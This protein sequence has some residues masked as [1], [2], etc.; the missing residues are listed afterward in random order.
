MPYRNP[1]DKAARQ[2]ARRQEQRQTAQAQR[3]GE[4]RQPARA[5][6]PAPLGSTPTP[7]TIVPTPMG[8]MRPTSLSPRRQLLDTYTRL[9]DAGHTDTG[10]QA[11]LTHQ[12]AKQRQQAQRDAHEREVGR[13]A[14]HFVAEARR[15]LSQGGSYTE[16]EV[17]PAARALAEHHLHDRQSAR[18]ADP[19]PKLLAAPGY[20]APGQVR[21][22]PALPITFG[23]IPAPI[24][25][26]FTT[27]SPVQAAEV[28]RQLEVLLAG[29]R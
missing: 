14:P 4:A 27:L 8:P 9:R 20:R 6:N 10:A 12:R 1:A 22:Q 2:R 11:Q 15:Q 29:R 16:V 5:H 25:Q 26:P 24:V 19:A 3:R 28:R 17:W 23:R 21:G 18:Q 7:A 13:L